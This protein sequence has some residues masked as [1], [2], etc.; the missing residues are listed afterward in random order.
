M[1]F[2]TNS[3]L[4]RLQFDKIEVQIHGSSFCFTAGQALL[5]LQQNNSQRNLNSYKLCYMGFLKSP[6]TK[7]SYFWTVLF[8]SP[9]FQRV[10]LKTLH[11]LNPTTWLLFDE[12]NF[13]LHKK[14][15]VLF[16]QS[17]S[18]CLACS[19]L[20]HAADVSSILHPLD[21]QPYHKYRW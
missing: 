14:Q 1:V 5:L 19:V 3:I 9:S 8:I 18:Q 13:S 20:K 17:A 21:I 10:V 4:D 15:L 11:I 6:H 12:Q 2:Q 7:N 16:L